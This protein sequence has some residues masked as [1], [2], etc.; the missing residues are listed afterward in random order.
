M[1]NKDDFK[2]KKKALIFGATKSAYAIYHSIAETYEIIGF[3]DNNSMKWNQE[4]MGKCIYPPDKLKDL[5]YDNIIIVSISSLY[6]I[7]EQLLNSGIEEGI[8]ITRYVES[9]IVARET[10]LRNFADIM[11]E[12]AKTGKEIE[13]SSVAEAGVFQGEFAKVINE[14]FSN[15]KLYL[16]DTFEGFDARDIEYEI[17]NGYS[18]AE[19]GELSLTSINMILNKMSHKEKCII[20]EGYFPETAQDINEFFCFVN[21]DMDLYKPT[22]EGLRFFYPRMVHGGIILIHDFF[23]KGYDGVNIAVKEFIEERGNEIIP[24]PI[25]DGVS[26]AIQKQ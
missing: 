6:I 1:S 21:L 19:Q 9:M 20:R 4:M 23:T 25:G 13:S 24:F 10:F 12:A 16:F 2:S 11:N 14:V 26:I 22:L 15:H 8:I 17:Q 5:E 18:E 3:M 7:K